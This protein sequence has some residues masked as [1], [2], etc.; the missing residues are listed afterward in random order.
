MFLCTCLL[1]IV[2]Y[3]YEGYAADTTNCHCFKDRTFNPADRFASDDYLLATTFNS[4][5]ASEFDISKGKIIMMK[6]REGVAGNDLVTAL[7]LSK[8][9][10]IDVP[11]LLKSKKTH[12]WKEIV[13]TMGTNADASKRNNRFHFITS[14]SSDEQ[15]A[16][17]IS[18]SIIAKRFSPPPDSLNNLRKMNLKPREIILAY[19]LGVIAGIPS[20]A[21]ADQRLKNGLSWSEIAHNLGLQPE[22]VGT[23]LER[24]NYRKQD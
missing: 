4:L 9:S 5:L 18:D 24:K 16:E 8:E 2:F 15:I 17:Y 3:Q 22:E 11:Q 20:E 19:T 6:M 7:Y 14:G 23:F 1:H 21:I 12:S 13:D 10:G